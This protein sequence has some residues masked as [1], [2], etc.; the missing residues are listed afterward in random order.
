MENFGGIAK[1]VE[2]KPDFQLD[3][4]KIEAALTDKTKAV[5]INSPNNPTGVVY[6]EESLKELANLLYAERKKGREY[7]YHF[8]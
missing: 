1:F 5:L 8:R 3:I 7:L 4:E 6:S 2:T